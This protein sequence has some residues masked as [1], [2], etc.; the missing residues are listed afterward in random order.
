MRGTEREREPRLLAFGACAADCLGNPGDA[1]VGSPTPFREPRTRACSLRSTCS[2]LHT[3]VHAVGVPACM[4]TCE[5][6]QSHTHACSCLHSATVRAHAGARVCI[7]HGHAYIY[8]PVHACMH[9]EAPCHTHVGP[10][11]YPGLVHMCVC[12]NTHAQICTHIPKHLHMLI[13]VCPHCRRAHTHTHR[14]SCM[15]LHTPP[16]HVHTHTF[17][18]VPAQACRCGD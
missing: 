13:H 14:Y 16:I 4:H 2:C 18:Q 15:Y 6:I 17:V 10:C 7:C 11:I 1:P 5:G 3:C 9:M 8:T 12:T